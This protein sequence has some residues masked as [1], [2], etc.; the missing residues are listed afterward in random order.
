M[1]AAVLTGGERCPIQSPWRGRRGNGWAA[2]FDT[3]GLVRSQSHR[4]G[5]CVVVCRAAGVAASAHA[6]RCASHL[7]S[8]GHGPAYDRRVGD[9]NHSCSPRRTRSYTHTERETDTCRSAS[10]LSRIIHWLHHWTSSASSHSLLGNRLNGS[11][12]QLV[13]SAHS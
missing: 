1:A 7:I 11:S 10:T 8:D 2:A 3:T 12:A 13:V 4:D 9:T 5:S 6:P